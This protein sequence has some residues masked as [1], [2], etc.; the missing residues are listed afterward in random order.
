MKKIFAAA[1]ALICILGLVSCANRPD[2]TENE[3]IFAMPSEISKVEVS[4]YYGGGVINAGDF[5]VEDFDKFAEWFYQLSLEHRTFDE[6]KNPGEMYAGGDEYT[7]DVNNGA[8][9][10]TYAIGGSPV[11]EYIIY[12]EEWYEV[13]NPSELPINDMRY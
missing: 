8:L 4:G 10:F 3:Q 2:G 13:L 1:L 7:F 12:E 9:T 5:V 6:G 11:T